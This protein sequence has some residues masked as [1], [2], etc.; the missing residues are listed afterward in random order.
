MLRGF[1][2]VLATSFTLAV[3]GL[4][5][6]MNFAFGDGLGTSPINARILAALAVTRDALK[7]TPAALHHPALG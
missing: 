7:C 3:I 6:A 4:S 2:T 1:W 5:M